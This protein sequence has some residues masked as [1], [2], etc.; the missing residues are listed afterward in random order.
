MQK[1]KDGNIIFSIIIPFKEYNKYLFETIE[2]IKNQ[3]YKNFELILLPDYKS[4]S[5]SG[6]IIEIPTGHLKPADKR[7]IGAK[8][9]QGEFLAFMDDDA[10]PNK[11]WLERSLEYFKDP[12][13]AMVCGPSLTPQNDSPKQLAS[14]KLY[15][16]FIVSGKFTYRYKLGK[17]RFVDDFPSSNMIVRKSI[18]QELGGFTTKY[19]PGEDTKLCLD[20][21]HKLRKKIL[22]SPE[23]YSYHHRR[24]VFIPHLK[25]IFSYARHRGFFV[26]KFP[27]TSRNFV[28]FIPLIFIFI[29]IVFPTLALIDKMFLWIYVFMILM[30][31]AIVS[32]ASINVRSLNLFGYVFV[33]IILTHFTY[34]IGFLK[35][36]IAKDFD[37]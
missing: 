16:S 26:K 36:L 29:F 2:Y 9:A 34:G 20:I 17:P 7:D 8:S 1:E 35:G 15:E 10:Y 11:K 14:G 6:G 21:V 28:Y 37:Y 13:I 5:K 27:Q 4:V 12:D 25:Q 22:Y 33:G 18:F 30:Y 19:W 24:K 32:F 31:L 3:T 23:L